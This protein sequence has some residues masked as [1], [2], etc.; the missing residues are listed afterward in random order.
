MKKVFCEFWA[1]SVTL[2]KKTGEFVKRHQMLFVL[3]LLILFT[4]SASAT[5][6]NVLNLVTYDDTTGSITWSFAGLLKLMVGALTA[7]IGA[8]AII[9]V[10]CA[11]YRFAKKFIK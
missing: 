2:L 5:D 6:T 3:A 7:A 8:G 11:G 10:I 4:V 1:P 9:F